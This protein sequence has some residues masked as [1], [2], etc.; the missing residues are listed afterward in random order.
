MGIDIWQGVMTTNNTPELIKKYGGDISFMGDLDSGTLDFPEWTADLVAE[1]VRRAC[2]NCGKEYFIPCL[3]MGGPES[4]FP[5]VY[6]KVNEEID[7]MSKEM[8]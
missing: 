6:D 1:H 5:G 4:L 7:K 2:T 8:F 3:T